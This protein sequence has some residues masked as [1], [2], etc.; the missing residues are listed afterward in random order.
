MKTGK[1]YSLKKKT[2][3]VIDTHFISADDRVNLNIG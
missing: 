2:H 1:I 3:G